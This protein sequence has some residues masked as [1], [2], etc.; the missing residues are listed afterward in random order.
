MAVQ[1]R[2]Q[3]PPTTEADMAAPQDQNQG[4]S[5][6]PSRTGSVGG[7]GSRSL[8]GHHRVK[9][10]I[11]GE[12]E[13]Q[14]PHEA[15]RK[16]LPQM[17]MP[18]T[19]KPPQAYSPKSTGSDSTDVGERPS[20]MPGSDHHGRLAESSQLSANERATRLANRLE[21]TS[22]PV[23]RRPSLE[24]AS[25]SPVPPSGSHGYPVRIDD[26]PLV[27]MNKRNDRRPYSLY[28]DSTDED[29]EGLHQV[30]RKDEKAMNGDP[31]HLDNMTRSMTKVEAHR[32]VRAMTRRLDLERTP[33][34]THH[35]HDELRSG[36][37][38]P[39]EERDP[40]AY[41]PK[42]TEFKPS[43][44]SML[45]K[46]YDQHGA[47]A[48]INRSSISGPSSSEYHDPRSWQKESDSKRGSLSHS[49][50]GTPGSSQQSSGRNT[51]HTS[52]TSTPKRSKW[53]EK[54][55]AAASSSSLAGLL[56]ASTMVGAPSS[57]NVA[58]AAHK[59]STSRPRLPHS[60]STGVL[61]SAIHKLAPKHDNPNERF[62]TVH[63]AQVLERQRYLLTLCRALMVYGAPTHRLE[64]YMRMS[65]RVLQIEGQFLYLPG[66]M[67]VSF[68]DSD[69]HTTEVKL[70]K[71]NQ[72][73][74]LGKFR[75]T[76]DIYKEVVH[77]LI[78]VEEA[79][80]RLNDIMKRPEK[81]NVWIKILMYGLASAFVGPFAFGA[82]PVDMP[83]AFVLG[84]VLGVLQLCLAP[85]SEL[86]S[87]VFEITASIVTSFA[88]RGMGSIRY[89]DGTSVFCFS[90]LA[91]SSIALILPGYVILC[92]S[93]ELQ[94][95]NL[96]AGSVRMVYAI[97]YALM[98]GFG[99]T[100]GTA[101]YGLMDKNATS[102]VTCPSPDSLNWWTNNVF[103]S[104][105]PWVPLFTM[106]L[107][108]INQAKWKQAPVMLVIAFTGYQVNFWSAQR[109][110]NNV[111]IA[112]ALG[113]F[114]IGVMGNLYARVRHGLAAA[115]LLP[116]IFVQVPSGLAASGS[117]V[118]GLTSADQ[119]T[120][121]ATGISVINNGTQGFAD[122]QNSTTMASSGPYSGTVFNLGYGMVQVAIGIT[123]GLFLSALVVYPL[124]K[125]RSG[126]FSF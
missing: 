37:I 112:N 21:S 121:N 49:I 41:V 115:A 39:L 43:I 118:S 105:F 66:C 114:A 33:A 58:S 94:S 61:S 46:V 47:G 56:D 85:R 92:S 109:F 51:P 77:D 29:D 44:L 6:S 125:K 1:D 89:R 79:M 23:S 15:P 100:I 82:R 98:L 42:P 107:I 34:Q 53:Y 95:R 35:D 84:C 16:P 71:A 31:D 65:A 36:Q 50:M 10:S 45:L 22:A 63:I 54:P 122:A 96:V 57:S 81:F 24:D 3:N 88:A 17:R 25:E 7:D 20:A 110:A 73:V 11:G 76:F 90:A 99:I 113:A 2:S 86:Y 102:V 59:P 52:G 69:L 8:R 104:R 117:L 93:L 60:G 62:I 18:P 120:G 83:V 72:G 80:Q 26:I 101:V 19:F 123:V 4:S 111:Q 91:Q 9:F 14:V 27:E 32:L 70:V 13:E 55:S 30:T 40:R 48:T 5:E 64:E 106:C 12:D 74:D 97:I 126:L 67:I 28:D 124:G 68:D 116:A 78:G 38:T 119:I 87:N 75:D 108:V 103:L